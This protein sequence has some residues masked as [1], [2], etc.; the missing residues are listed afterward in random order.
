[1]SARLGRWL[2]PGLVV[3]VAAV[4]VMAESSQAAPP[5]IPK[6]ASIEDRAQGPFLLTRD[7]RIVVRRGSDRAARVANGL[8]ALLRRSTG[9]PIAVRERRARGPGGPAIFLGL[10]RSQRLGSEGYRLRV[11]RHAVRLSARTAEG[12]FRATQTLRQLLPAKV[13]SASAQPGPWRV[14]GM[15]VVDRPRFRLRGAHLDVSRHFFSVDEVKGYIDLI[16]QYKVN[17]LHLHLS[18][19]QG[20]R[21]FIDS[22]PR[23]ATHGGSTEVGGGPGGYYTR[24]DYREIVRYAADRYMTLVPEIDTPG[25]TNAAL[26]SYAELNCDGQ[27]PPLYTGTEVGFSSLC[28]DK[29]ITYEFLDDVVRE[30]ARLT[31]GRY[32]HMGGDE[33]QATEEEDY[34]RFVER[35]Q[36]IVKRHGKLLMGWEE[37]A[38]AQLLPGTLAQHWST[39]T[40][41]EPGT[42]LARRAVAQG[43]K[44]VMSPANHAYL[45]MK[46][47]PS[48][49]LGL[50]WAG[51]VEVRDAY[52]WDPAELVDGVDEDDVA[53]VESAL[54]SET[55]EDIDDV[56]FMAVPRLPGIAE[57][58]W[59]PREGRDWSEYRRRLA[60]QGP[61]WEAQG[62]NFYRS[63]QVPWP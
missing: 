35:L 23:L 4:S 37:I 52:E 7:T 8:A 36:Q 60:A 2:M 24:Q 28:I 25:H 30:L 3:F 29:E 13:E 15:R 54:W 58:G 63:P 20:W 51:F 19:D 31:P 27:A 10:D 48:T 46:Y 55:L 47:D 41:S 14:P 44:L 38:Q 62:V 33:A 18:D 57:I 42:E 6:P 45:D 5:V 40:G 9:Y 34:V 17:V 12:L 50:S 22:W 56:E 49:P 16:A 39:A 61:R 59:S 11:S 32:L 26:A 53:G 21:I 1:M 43:L